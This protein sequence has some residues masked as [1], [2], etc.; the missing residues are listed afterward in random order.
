MTGERE[1]ERQ[2]ER[3]R[4]GHTDILRLNNLCLGGRENVK[5]AITKTGFGK[6]KSEKKLVI[7]KP[8]L[9]CKDARS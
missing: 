2:R 7:S 9:I 1:R 3:E 6:I 4:K 8:R 5:L